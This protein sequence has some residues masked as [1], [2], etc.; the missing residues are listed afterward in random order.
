VSALLESISR[1]DFAIHLCNRQ[2]HRD[3]SAN[4]PFTPLYYPLADVYFL[5]ASPISFA[6]LLG[7]V[8]V[9]IEHK[10]RLTEVA[11]RL[12]PS[13]ESVSRIQFPEDLFESVFVPQ[14]DTI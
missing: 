12:N 9:E 14:V 2:H 3:P 6:D 11:S 7:I 10:R 8:E 1:E 13:G 4:V 5:K